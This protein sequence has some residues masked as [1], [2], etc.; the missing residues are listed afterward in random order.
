M[1]DHPAA[2]ASR[3]ECPVCGAAQQV[4]PDGGAPTCRRCRAD[5]GAFL[6]T[7]RVLAVHK[8]AAIAAARGGDRATAAA[9]G[10][11]L[12]WL[13]PTDANAVRAICQLPPSDP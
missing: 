5:L 11:P 1:P 10:A 7:R 8:V 3:I 13:D 9:F 2:E 12:A 4:P 6:Q